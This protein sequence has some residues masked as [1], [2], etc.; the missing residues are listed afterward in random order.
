MIIEIHKTLNNP[1]QKDSKCVFEFSGKYYD[2]YDYNFVSVLDCFITT[3]DTQNQLVT[4]GTS[5]IDRTPGNPNQTIHKFFK[6]HRKEKY[7]WNS[8]T[9]CDQYKIQC[10]TFNES[11]FTISFLQPV[12]KID[13]QLRLKFTKCLTDSAKQ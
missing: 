8:P 2:I 6:G 4:I 3:D 10:F 5:I 12:K 7:L 1:I 9:R 13:L 11:V